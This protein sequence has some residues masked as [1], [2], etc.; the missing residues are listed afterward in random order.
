[1]DTNVTPPI[2]IAARELVNWV[3]QQMERNTISFNLYLHH[4]HSPF[5]ISLPTVPPGLQ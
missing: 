2:P 5:P 4:H 3:V 1:M